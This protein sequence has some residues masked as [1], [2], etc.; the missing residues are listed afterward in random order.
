[1]IKPPYLCDEN[2]VDLSRECALKPKLPN[3]QKSIS[4]RN[5]AGQFYQAEYVEN[6]LRIKNHS[7]NEKHTKSNGFFI[8]AGAGDGEIISNSLYFELIHKVHIVMKKY[9]LME[10]L[11]Y[12]PKKNNQIFFIFLLV[13][14]SGLVC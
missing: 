11:K 5:L 6:L 3:L 1:M 10:N 7:K 9:K 8:E 14:C 13:I 12:F 4:H 2:E